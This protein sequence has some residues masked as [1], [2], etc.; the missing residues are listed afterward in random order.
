MQ[1][2]SIKA[3]VKKVVKGK[4]S[5]KKTTKSTKTCTTNV[6]IIL[7]ES[8]SMGVQ[9]EKTITAINEYIDTIA[10]DDSTKT[11]IFVTF[12]KFASSHGEPTTRILYDGIAIKNVPKLSKENYT[13]NGMTPLLDAIGTTIA[14]A[15]AHTKKNNKNVANLV[16]IV[17]DGEEN[18]SQEYTKQQ[19]NDIVKEKE[20]L[21]WTFVFIGAGID[22]FGAAQ[23]AGT[24]AS[25]TFSASLSN[26]DQSLQNAA[27]GTSK[28]LRTRNK[29]ASPMMM[30][31]YS[32]FFDGDAGVVGNGTN[33]S[34]GSTTVNGKT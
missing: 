31:S 4:T 32:N 26:I 12:V 11:P 6:S 1:T 28:Y 10:K 21:G 22:A 33:T 17:T 13:P 7:D 5:P 15:A 14:S 27:I 18:S 23:Y 2:K 34:D 25:N 19:I 3:K 16:V 8:S 29:M 30:S 20:D 24:N 9:T